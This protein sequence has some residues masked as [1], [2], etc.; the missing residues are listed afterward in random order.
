M[1]RPTGL[2]LFV[3]IR[4]AA[5]GQ[6]QEQPPAEETPYEF[7]SGTI[8]DLPA[9]KIVINRAVLGKPPE[10]RTFVITGDTKVEGKLRVGVRVTVGFKP[11]EEHDEPVAMRIIVR[12]PVPAPKQP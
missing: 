9:G 4:G 11:S 8:S 3:L 6:A 10:E 12:P 7:V 1:L 5:F 2:L